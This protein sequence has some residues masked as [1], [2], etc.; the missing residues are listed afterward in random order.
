MQTKS[1]YK[2]QVWSLNIDDGV[3]FYREA[4]FTNGQANLQGQNVQLT[5]S[6]PIWRSRCPM[7][8]GGHRASIRLRTGSR[9]AVSMSWSRQSEKCPFRTATLYHEGTSRWALHHHVFGAVQ[10]LPSL[11]GAPAIFMAMAG[12]RARPLNIF[13]VFYVFIGSISVVMHMSVTCGVQ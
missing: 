7:Q 1:P 12:G 6:L 9:R 2:S 13:S 11:L 5:F 3:S 4:I 10:W 8:A